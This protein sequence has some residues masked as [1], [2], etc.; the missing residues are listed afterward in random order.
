[1][2]EVTVVIPNYNGEKY[3]RPCIASVYDNTKM[4]IEII[5]V[6][7]GSK[8]GSADRIKSE[9]PQVKII[10]LGENYGF[11]KAVNVGIL[12]S[13][14]PYVLLLNNDTL[15]KGNFVEEL[16]NSAKKNSQ[17]FSV[18]AKMLQ[19]ND[20]SK[21]DS[22]GTYYNIFCWAIARGK[23]RSK[24]YYNKRQ[25]SFAACGG[26][27]LYQRK[28]F[29]KI[30]LF[31]EMHFA[32]LE[33]VDIG[34]R[35]QIFGYTN[36]YEPRAEVLHVGSASSGS[37]YNSFKTRHSARNNIYVLYKNMPFLQILLNSP[38][39]IVGIIIKMCFFIYKGFGKEYIYAI[40]EGIRTCKFVDKVPFRLSNLRHYFKIQLELWM[41]IV[42]TIF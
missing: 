29:D 28:V 24:E 30:G 1:M 36:I 32:Y 11:C 18:E 41:N 23:G 38:F 3:L 5:V 17:I 4:E 9:F 22:A 33:D 40:I 16:L 19:W 26:A 15:L 20:S 14:T 7:N 10:L 13:K 25:C 8:D 42:Y 37:R 34:Y 21:I 35:A 27:A 31:D 6:D 2:K 12:E 39:I